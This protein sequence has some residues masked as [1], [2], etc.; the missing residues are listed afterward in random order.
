MHAVR[1][2]NEAG[3]HDNIIM[4]FRHGPCYEEEEYYI[5]MEVCDFSL[6]DYV[7]RHFPDSGNNGPL[8]LPTS[9]S[10]ERVCNIMKDILKGVA[11]IHSKNLIHRDLKPAN[12]STLTDLC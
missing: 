11:F 9:A 8:Y 10:V 1:Q 2:L 12:C 4:I 6:E 7:G 5:D 3:V